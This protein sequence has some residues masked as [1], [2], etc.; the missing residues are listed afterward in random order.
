MFDFN[1]VAKEKASEKYPIPRVWNEIDIARNSCYEQGFIDGAEHGYDK[2]CEETFDISLSRI[3]H[4][5]AVVIQDN[6]RLRKE[7][8]RLRKEKEWHRDEV[9]GNENDILCQVAKDD[10]VVGYYHQSK[11]RYYTTD[12]QDIDVIAWKEIIPPKQEE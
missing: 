10:F 3:T 1:K 4:E 11:K 12:G 5:R 7:N 2:K 9:P 8:E 6:E